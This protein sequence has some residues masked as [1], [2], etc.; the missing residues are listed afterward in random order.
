M[1]RLTS[2]GILLLLALEQV[3][4]R[5]TLARWMPWVV[6]VGGLAL[7]KL[8]PSPWLTREAWVQVELVEASASR[9][10]GR[11]PLIELAWNWPDL[12]QSARCMS[13]LNV[14]L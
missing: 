3:S 13:S 4:V 7:C 9:L 12:G 14:E 11:I 6:D 1:V 2:Y 8:D 5:E 10:L